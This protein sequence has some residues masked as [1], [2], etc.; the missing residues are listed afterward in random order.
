M[1]VLLYVIHC[2]HQAAHSGM[3]QIKS[4]QKKHE[5][6]HA[7]NNTVGQKCE[8]YQNQFLARKSGLREERTQALI[9]TEKL[10]Y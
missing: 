8:I 6:L 1:C 3:H 7:T 10:T 2:A 9:L 5:H 4:E